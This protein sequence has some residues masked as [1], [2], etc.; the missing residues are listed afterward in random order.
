MFVYPKYRVVHWFAED[1]G[2]EQTAR[3]RSLDGHGCLGMRV[4]NWASRAQTLP[5]CRWRLE[6]K[7]CP[8]GRWWPAAG[9]EK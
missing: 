4:W 1:P 2:T 6:F 8:F 7:L 3:V 5:G 9:V